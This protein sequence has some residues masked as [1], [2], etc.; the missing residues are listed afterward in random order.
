[1]IKTNIKKDFPHHLNHYLFTDKSIYVADY[2]KQT[3][4]QKGI[5]IFTEN[6]PI[7]IDY[8]SLLNDNKLHVRNIIF[9]NKSFI[10][11]NGNARSQCECVAFP[12]IS[13]INS[14]V[15]FLELKYSNKP[16]NNTNNLHKAINQLYKTRT[17]YYQKGIFHKS[18]ICYLLAS[19]PMQREP[20]ANFSITPPK[21]QTLKIKHN[22]VLRLQNKAT[23]ENDNNIFV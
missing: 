17:Y 14:W 22:V 21:L 4:S 7:T 11:P 9:N 5:E 3:Q 8:F 15:L 19:L 13:H 6:P 12:E 18:N 2:T 23:I 1:M 16:Y 20:F 10:Y